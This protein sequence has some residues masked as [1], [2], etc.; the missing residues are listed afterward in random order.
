MTPPN[1]AATRR[2]LYVVNEDF[3]FLLNR[4]RMARAAREAGFEVHVA[5]NVNKGAARPKA[6]SCIGSLSGAAGCRPFRRSRRCWRSVASKRKSSQPATPFGV[7][8]LR[9]W[10]GRAAGQ[11]IS[12]GQCDHRARLHLHL[13]ELADGA[14]AAGM[15]WVLPWLLNR[16]NSVVLVLNPDDRSKL[17]T[18]GIKPSRT[19][20]IPW[21]RRPY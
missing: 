7:A 2:L 4:L 20:P 14:V 10:L 17:L 6:S 9:L 21:V 15:V 18:L 3:A 8:V 13:G 11:E 19:A 1:S 12:D 5:T 16:K